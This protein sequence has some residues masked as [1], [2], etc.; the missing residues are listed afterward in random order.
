VGGGT[1]EFFRGGGTIQTGEF[2]KLNELQGNLR[3]T[4]YARGVVTQRKA[5][6]DTAPG[7]ACSPVWT[8]GAQELR[9]FRPQEC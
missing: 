6:P 8:L 5:A 3:I 7:L 2:H 9:G 4:I 1:D